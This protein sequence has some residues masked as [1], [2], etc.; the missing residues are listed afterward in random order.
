MA[1]AAL[2]GILLL[3]AGCHRAQHP[4]PAAP[5]ALPTATVRTEAVGSQSQVASAEVAGTVRAKL[6]ATLEAKVS[7]RIEKLPVVLGQTVKTGDLLVQL[8]V[9]EVQARLDQAVAL[10]RQAERELQRFTALLKQEAVTQ[11][12]FDAVE[13]RSRVADAS[14]AEAETMLDYAKVVAPF[15]GIIT[16]KLTDVGDLASPGR[17]LVEIEDPTVFRMEADVPEALVRRLKLGDRLRVNIP[18]VGGELEG[19]V[20]ELAPV[21][22]PASRTFR[23]TLDLPPTAELRTGQF[24]RVAVPLDQTEALRVPVTAVVQRGQMELVFVAT[25]GLA[26][27]RL[28]KTGKRSNGVVELLSGVAP[29]EAVVVEG[30]E[31]D[32]GDDDQRREFRVNEGP[33]HAAS[34]AETGV[35]WGGGSAHGKGEGISD[36]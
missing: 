8:D 13:A 3:S 28:V 21:A 22:D 25:N 33:G 17:P 34:E 4:T 14:V 27:M 23:V 36:F 5:P 35:W 10:R 15:N 26:Q 7:G 30:A 9:R 31:Q 2:A 19:V 29:G 18:T 11:A 12:E 16:R 24:G 6:R 20:A 32:R 1:A